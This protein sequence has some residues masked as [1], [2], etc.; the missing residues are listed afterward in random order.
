MDMLEHVYSDFTIYDDNFK[1][2]QEIYDMVAREEMIFDVPLSEEKTRIFDYE[3][4][5]IIPIKFKD[6]VEDLF[7]QRRYALI[8]LYEVPIGITKYHK[9]RKHR[10]DDNRFNLPIFYADYSCETGINWEE[11]STGFSFL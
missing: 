5:S 1:R 4:V 10:Y 11:I 8:P 2:A 6:I 9:L 7:A 3:K